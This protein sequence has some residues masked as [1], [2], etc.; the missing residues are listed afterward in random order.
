M[1]TRITQEMAI[2]YGHRLEKHE[3]KCKNV[4]GHRGTIQI[5]VEADKLDEVGRVI[6]FGVVKAVVGEWLN[7]TLD[8]GIVLQEYDPMVALL[9]GHTKM[10]TM[11]KPPTAENL[12]ELVFH[13][14]KRL[15]RP[16][17]V[18]VVKVRFWETP[19]CYADYEGPL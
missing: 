3:S 11:P 12:A 10:F 5:T 4:H 15:M 18:R 19:F 14:A 17:G 2:D 1:P 6:D 8:H 7:E 13:Q 9:H 16:H